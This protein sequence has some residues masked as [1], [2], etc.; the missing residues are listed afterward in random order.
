MNTCLV[1][2]GNTRFK[3]IEE[4]RLAEGLKQRR[5]YH[6]SAPV[7]HLCDEIMRD[8]G[9]DSWIVASVKGNAFDR[10]LAQRFLD[11]G[12]KNIRFAAIPESPPFELAYEHREKFG[13]DRYLNLLAARTEHKLPL[14]VI[15]AGTA[16]TIDALDQSGAHR[17]GIIFPGLKLLRSCLTHG[18]K[19]VTAD[20]AAEALL[21]G[22]TTESCVN[23]G[24]YHGLLGA[25]D[26][27]VASMCERLDGNVTILFT[28]GDAQLLAPAVQFDATLDHNLLLK[29]LRKA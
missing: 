13:I 25:I 20:E 10:D 26:G 28:G 6:P 12:G 15:D 24:S 16:V 27:I 1:D 8:C 19:Q 4:S 17:G 23:G 7:T 2:L 3:W 22:N 9:C 18:A 14:L 29:G 5:T 21:F 11:T